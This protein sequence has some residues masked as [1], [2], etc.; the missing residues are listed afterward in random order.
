MRAFSHVHL[1]KAQKLFFF[2][3]FWRLSLLLTLS[4]CLSLPGEVRSGPPGRAKQ[5]VPARERGSY[6]QPEADIF[7]SYCRVHF[8]E[9]FLSLF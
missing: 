4:L 8:S 6:S 1:L 9:S 7:L 3:S 2:F 5:R